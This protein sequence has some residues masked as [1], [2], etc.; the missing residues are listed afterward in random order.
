MPRNYK[1]TTKRTAKKGRKYPDGYKDEY[2][3][4]IIQHGSKGLLWN[5][6]AGEIKVHRNTVI[7][8]TNKYPEFKEAKE[9]ADVC[10]ELYWQKKGANPPRNFNFGYC[11][12]IMTNKYGYRD[13][14]NS[15]NNENKQYII[16]LPMITPITKNDIQ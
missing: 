3:K 15:Q 1:K 14:I 11:K 9:I 13:K 2:C 16:E 8:W 12:M 10:C 6:F 5:T 7:N 4:R